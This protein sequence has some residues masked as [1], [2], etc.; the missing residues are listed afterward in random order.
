MLVTHSMSATHSTHG[1][2]VEYSR[3]E[4]Q[5]I[6]INVDQYAPG[7][8]RRRTSLFLSNDQFAVLLSGGSLFRSNEEEFALEF[9]RE[10]QL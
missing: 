2:Q 4:D 1:I 5:R 9:P 7:K 10:F 6:L 8:L 3:L